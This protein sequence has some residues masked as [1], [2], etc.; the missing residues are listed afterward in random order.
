MIKI[1]VCSDSH[2]AKDSIEKLIESNDF[3]FFFFLGDGLQDLGSYQNLESLFA[4]KGNCDFFS[5]EQSQIITNISSKKILALHGNGHGVKYGLGALI[6]YA[7][8]VK[9]D[10]VL[11]GHTHNFLADNIDDIWFFNPGSLKNGSYLVVNI[12]NDSVTF[13]KY[14]I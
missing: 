7:K 4:V 1:L 14:N 8:E 11:F 5:T 2:G 6:K 12:D 13:N 3:D 9:A 10:I